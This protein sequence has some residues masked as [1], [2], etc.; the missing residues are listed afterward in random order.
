M[1]VADGVNQTIRKVNLLKYNLAG[2]AGNN[3]NTGMDCQLLQLLAIQEESHLT[4]TILTLY[5]TTQVV[6]R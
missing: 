2:I 1:Y 5:V 3:G 6:E 4:K